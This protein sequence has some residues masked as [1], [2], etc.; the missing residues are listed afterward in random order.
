MEGRVAIASHLHGCTVSVCLKNY[1]CSTAQ[2]NKYFF[3]I[4]YLKHS[5]LLG[6]G[7]LQHVVKVVEPPAA[8]G[9]EGRRRH[10]LKYASR[11]SPVYDCGKPGKVNYFY[12]QFLFMLLRFHCCTLKQYRLGTV[13]F[14][15]SIKDLQGPFQSEIEFHFVNVTCRAIMIK[16]CA[17]MYNSFVSKVSHIDR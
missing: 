17:F 11:F 1:P 2:W 15:H 13:G 10:P 12:Q 16:M 5:S 9:R 7:N 14:L 6:K 8:A 3:R 4:L